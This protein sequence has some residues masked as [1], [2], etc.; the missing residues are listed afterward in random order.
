MT[1][2]VFS[3]SLPLAVLFFFFLAIFTVPALPQGTSNQQDQIPDAPAPNN[4]APFP[5][6]T[7]PAPKTERPAPPPASDEPL[8]LPPPP[9]AS[10]AKPMPISNRPA[11]ADSNTRDELTAT[12]RKVVNFVVVPVTVKDPD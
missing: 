6:N 3:R 9:T 4:P 5:A 12:F 7:A 11:A 10:A 8:P 2:K 1:R